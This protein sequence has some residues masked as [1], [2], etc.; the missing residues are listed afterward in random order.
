VVN[1]RHSLPTE[2]WNNIE[3]EP[4]KYERMESTITPMVALDQLKKSNVHGWLRYPSD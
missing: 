2:I 1:E 3:G 4:E